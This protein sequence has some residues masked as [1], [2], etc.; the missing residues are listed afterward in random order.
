MKT[1]KLIL[2]KTN[3]A[4]RLEG[5][6]FDELVAS[7]KE[8]G[9]LMPVLVRKI[10]GGLEVV[11]GN[12]RVAAAHAAG[13]EDKD[14]P[15]RVV[16][17]N[18]REAQE[19]QIIENLQRKDV[20]PLDEAEAYK[21]LIESAK[22]KLDVAEV[23]AKV[24][25][26]ITYVRNRLVLTNLGGKVKLHVRSGMLPMAH[27]LEIARLNPEGQAE[28]FKF[29]TQYNRIKDLAELREFI[30]QRTFK[31]L[32]ETPPW[33]DDEAMKAEISRITG[34]TEESASTDLFGSKTFEK[35]EDPADYA[36]ALA[37][38][39][40]LTINK[41]KAEGKDL[42]LISSEYHTKTKGLKG[43][44]DYETGNGFYGKK[45]CGSLH[46]ALV[47]EG[48]DDLGKIIKI[49]TNKG[50]ASHHYE[51]EKES[52][53][54]KEKQKVAR[55]KE[56]A[57]AKAKKQ[58]DI[59]NMTAAVAKF[60]WP[61][62]EKQLGILTDLAIKRGAH[63]VHQQAVGRRGIEV[64][65]QKTSWGQYKSYESTLIKAAEK[66]T[67]KEKV[68]LLFEMLVPGFS[69]NYTEGR[70]VVFNKL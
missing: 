22:P 60:K 1:E 20:H 38:Y 15:M 23:A 8:K 70:T 28:A 13:I 6:D 17:M 33:K 2:S 50:C 44:A 43:K 5:P 67:A 40:E 18:D 34:I 39:I 63:D 9:V 29:T 69:P 64:I 21:A 57:A 45:K 61:L 32:R 30:T 36:R 7:I 56:I 47:V 58:K 24:G 65:K 3:P 42:T 68:G 53:A 26:S 16:E 55:K 49:C 51:V 41:Y 27:A 35:I 52:P 66:M 59:D 37:A 4:G 62:T 12:R 14:I 31:K 54:G 46:D 48:D 11:A 10:K 25:K 19:A